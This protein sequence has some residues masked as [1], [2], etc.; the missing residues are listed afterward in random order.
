VSDPFHLAVV[1]FAA[2]DFERARDECR[3]AAAA[4]PS[5]RLY[6]EGAA[7]LDRV[8]REG[9]R[10]V[11]VSADGF[12]AFIRGGGNVGLY[13][14][15]SAALR[16]V[17]G[18]SDRLRLLDLGVGDGLALLPAIDEHVA[19]VT[20]VEP[21]ADMLRATAEALTL[22]GVTH[23]AVCATAQDFIAAHPDGVSA[24]LV[25]ATFSLQS[26][27]RDQRATILSWV[28]RTAP[29]LLIAEF[30]V[31]ELAV[32]CTPDDV[33][34]LVARYEAGLAAQ[35]EGGR[36]GVGLRLRNRRVLE[37]VGGPPRG[38]ANGTY[39]LRPIITPQRIY[40]QSLY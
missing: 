4:A 37:D 31:R 32:P 17:Y 13:S 9:P 22:R 25:Q 6:A 35:L 18:A 11:Y 19:S 29:R 34:H 39:F 10:N 26:I 24:D 28:S 15:T 7:Y 23:D 3:R 36:H 1:A 33:R 21:S 5:S 2:Q 12:R 38:P 16:A 27:P 30:D 40:T 8:V 20:L 14:A